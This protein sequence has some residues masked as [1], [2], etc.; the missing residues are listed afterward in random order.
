[1]VKSLS[2]KFMAFLSSFIL[3]SAVYETAHAES[4]NKQ[5]QVVQTIDSLRAETIVTIKGVVERIRDE[6]EFILSDDTGSIKV[7]IGSNRMPVEMGDKVTVTGM[8]DNDI[9]K[10]EVYAHEI[11]DQSG[12]TTKLERRYD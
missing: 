11:I 3:F 6:D 12:N 9:I 1:M 8:Y 2:S 7:Y 4:S 5:D 10:R